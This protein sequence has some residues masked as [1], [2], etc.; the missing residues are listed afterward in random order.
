MSEVF[1][2]AFRECLRQILRRAPRIR[3]S[4]E[5]EAQG[6]R[7][8]MAQSGT[9]AGH[10]AYYDGD[11]LRY[12]DWNAYARTGDLFLKVL[13]EDDRRTLT[14]CVDC[15][16]SMA[17][18]DP[19]RFRGAQRLAA[20]L[21]G[22]ALVGLDGLT[23]V[24][25]EGHVHSLSGASAVERLLLAL[26][27][28]R[29]KSGDP[30]DLLRVPVER[31]WPGKILW[32]SDFAD[33]EAAAPGLHLLRRRGR[34]C[35]G[36][37]PALAED[38]EPVLDGRSRLRDPETGEEHV[39]DVDGPLRAAMVE[40]LRLLARHQD[41]IF[42]AVGYPLVRFPLPEQGDF[43]LSSWFTGPWTYRL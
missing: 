33:P 7:K 23:L 43:R 9:F 12:V 41:A 1:P 17:T 22:L 40:E 34:A 25:G 18:G 38:R 29:P 21:G 15:S 8:M 35:V 4:R 5:R 3:G 14:V 36:W 32:I 27:D 42:H 13:E 28:I 16:P 39:L 2:E 10:R 19:V 37:L 26:A 6:R 20:I 24:A 11:D 31:G 30:V